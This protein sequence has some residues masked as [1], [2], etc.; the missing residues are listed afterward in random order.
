MSFPLLPAVDSFQRTEEHLRKGNNGSNGLPKVMAGFR[1]TREF[2][3]DTNN[4]YPKP[5][6]LPVVRVDVQESTTT[7]RTTMQRGETKEFI[8]PNAF[9]NLG[10]GSD[11]WTLSL[12]L[13][14][15]PLSA[16]L[17]WYTTLQLKKEIPLP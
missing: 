6:I 5:E 12:S 3:A 16:L 8:T 10:N 14:P 2:F 15:L 11:G 4:V 7:R 9:I 17:L 13:F 1:T